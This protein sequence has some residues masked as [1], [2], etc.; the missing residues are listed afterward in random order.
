MTR[1][2][3]AR[4]DEL[5]DDRSLR[6]LWF[7][8]ITAQWCV[9]IICLCLNSLERLLAQSKVDRFLENEAK[10]ERLCPKKIRE[11][12]LSCWRYDCRYKGCRRTL[13]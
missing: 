7:A 3:F 4:G 9:E 12:T 13:D 6:A 5:M 11:Y 10:G 2:A 1:F 8:R